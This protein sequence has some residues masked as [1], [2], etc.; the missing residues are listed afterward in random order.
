V[1]VDDFADDFGLAGATVVAF[2]DSAGVMPDVVAASL[3]MAFKDTPARNAQ[4]AARG[5]RRTIGC[6]PL[7]APSGGIWRNDA[8]LLKG[9]RR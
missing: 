2:R 4:S 1:Y 6:P 7:H 9:N 8:G 3:A 5:P